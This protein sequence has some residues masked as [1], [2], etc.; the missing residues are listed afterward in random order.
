MNKL[1]T[2]VFLFFSTLFSCQQKSSSAPSISPPDSFAAIPASASVVPDMAE[3]TTTLG[4][5]SLISRAT[6][7]ILSTEPTEEPPNFRIFIFPCS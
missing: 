4:C 7:L 2:G 6:C 3:S 5:S 1:F